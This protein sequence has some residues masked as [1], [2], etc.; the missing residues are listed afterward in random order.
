MPEATDHYRHHHKPSHTKAPFP[1]VNT[2]QRYIPAT[3]PTAA[4][5][6]T[7]RAPRAFHVWRSRDN[8]KG[9]HALVVAPEYV[10]EGRHE[11]PRL[12]AHWREVLR[13]IAKMFLRYPVWDISYDVAAIFTIGSVIWV[14]NGFFS[15]LPLAAPSTT[16][17]GEASWGGGVTALVG[18]TVFEV[19][20]VLLM[21]E[22]VNENRADC[23]GWAVEES[24]DGLLKLHSTHSCRHHHAQTRTFV[25]HPLTSEHIP[26]KAGQGRTWSWLP[27]WHELR[28]HYIRD[29]GFLASSAQLLGATI[30]WI[31]G[32]TAI[33]PILSGFSTP[34]ENGLYWF[35]QVLGGVG[36]IVSGFLFMVEVQPHWYMPAP[37][38]LGWHIGFWNLVGAIGFTL[39]GALGFGAQREGVEYALTLATFIGSWAFLIGSVIQLYE[40]LNKYT[41]W[42]V[43][44]PSKYA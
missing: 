20:S 35:P 41:L 9:R 7:R 25:Q 22:A 4:E 6:T 24:L 8:R 39:C 19:G 44:D 30:F 29:L 13:G 18:A 42:V 15:W 14:I 26:T 38:V 40:S 3:L 43:K 2:T 23:F 21:L 11:G 28:T 34:A 12:S 27:T 16:F 17:P 5:K 37:R 10:T 32:I 33:P 1:H 31:A 36:F